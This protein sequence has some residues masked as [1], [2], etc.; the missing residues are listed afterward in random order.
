MHFGVTMFQTDFAMNVVDVGRAVEERGFESL[1]LP[2]HMHIPATRV[3]P[4]P[5]GGDLPV[6]YAHTLDPFV[7]L[8]AVSAV[9]SRLK[10]GTG[11]CL[12][13]QR[14]PIHLAKEVA[15]LDLLSAGR[16]LFGVGAGWLLEEIANHGVEPRTRW[17][18]FNE[19]MRAMQAIWSS[20]NPEFHGRYVDFPPILSWPKPVQKPC[21]PVLLGG[22]YAAAIQR[23]IEFGDEWMPHADRGDKAF[24]QR[25]AEFWE[26]SEAAGRG[27]MPVTVFGAKADPRLVDEYRSA[28]VARCVFRLPAGPADE[29]MPVL[30]QTADLVRQFS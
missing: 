23:V 17:R 10:L 8:A 20:D 27:R 25:V 16:F 28:G 22:D 13:I 30:D 3:T 7:A 29:V 5:Q 9:T 1:L 11:V 14:D 15:S 24:K 21:P 4:W 6:A 12:V 18:V 26:V 19:R 2:E